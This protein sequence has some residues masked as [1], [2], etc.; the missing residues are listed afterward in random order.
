MTTPATDHKW[1]RSLSALTNRWGVLLVL[2]PGERRNDHGPECLPA[3][4][5]CVCLTSML[6]SARAVSL[7]ATP[8]SQ[9]T[10]NGHVIPEGHRF[11]PDP[12]TS[13]QCQ[14]GLTTCMQSACALP[15]CVDFVRDPNQCCP[16]CPNG[17]NCRAPDGTIVPEGQEVTISTSQACRCRHTGLFGGREAVCDLVGPLP[18]DSQ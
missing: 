18:L 6:M 12:C 15:D 5:V 4:T 2:G 7:R 10:W 17:G 16:V 11:E 8:P 14:H 1:S 9:C 13:C 3:L